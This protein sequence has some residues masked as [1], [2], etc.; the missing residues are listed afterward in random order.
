MKAGIVGASGYTGAEL[1][2]LFAGH[3]D[4]EVAVV[5][6][7][8]H[9]G[10]VVGRHTPSLA[11][12][13]PGLVYE[14]SDPGRPRRPRRRVLRPAARRVAADRPR[15]AWAASA[16]SS[17]SPPTSGSRTRRSTRAGTAT[18][19]P[20]PSSSE[21]SAYGLP[22]L[23]RDGLAGAT[24]RGRG[25][26]ATRPRPG[27]RSPRSCGPGWSD[28]PGSSSTPPAGVSGA[29]RGLKEST[30]L[31]HGG[32]GLHRLRAARP[33]PHA[34]DRAD[35]RRPRCCSPRIWPP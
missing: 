27:W 19:T 33:P 24:A 31:R 26:A 6:A 18:S 32:R 8:S 20:R 4:L 17:T 12:A 29:G 30:A 25:R 34:R 2:R 22:E 10:E 16:W 14:D 23:F 9:A 13:Y 35:P 21:E 15:A 1:L 28:R 7:D 11:A 3:P 5:T